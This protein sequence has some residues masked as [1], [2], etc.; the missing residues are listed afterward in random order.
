MQKFIDWL[1]K[2]QNYDPAR[3]PKSLETLK[4]HQRLGHLVFIVYNALPSAHCDLLRDII[5]GCQCSRDVSKLLECGLLEQNPDGTFYAPDYV[6]KEI[7]PWAKFF[8]MSHP[9]CKSIE[10]VPRKK[11]RSHKKAMIHIK[12]D[13]SKP[14][15][16]C[17]QYDE[18]CAVCRMGDEHIKYRFTLEEVECY[19]ASFSSGKDSR[20]GYICK[21]HLEKCRASDEFTVETAPRLMD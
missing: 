6:K 2:Y 17:Y 15:Q 5:L 13:T 1:L 21:D 11:K 12:V 20:S 7:L 10:D 3:F 8:G 18:G 16:H 4:P 19:P 14:E 9:G